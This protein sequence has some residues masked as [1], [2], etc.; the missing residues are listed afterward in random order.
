MSN[1]LELNGSLYDLSETQQITE[2][3]SKREF[4][5]EI[6]SGNY[7]HHIKCEATGKICSELDDAR[8]GS[9][10]IAKCE[11]RGRVYQRKDGTK[12]QMNTVVAWDIKY[13]QAEYI[14]N[15]IQHISAPF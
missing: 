15:S 8:I 3:F 6:P 12:G 10:V 7:L 1:Q 9:Q 13:K 2:K 11:L 4:I 14:D 5:L